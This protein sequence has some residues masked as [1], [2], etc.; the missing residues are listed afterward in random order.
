MRI[1][2]TV[3]VIL[4]AA[5]GAFGVDNPECSTSGSLPKDTIFIGYTR[6]NE[7]QLN[8]LA[9][10]IS[11]HLKPY[12]GHN[13]SAGLLLHETGSA[14][15]SK[16]EI[17]AVKPYMNIRGNDHCEFPAELSLPAS[18]SWRIWVSDTALK[19][20][21]PNPAERDFFRKLM[22]DCVSQGDYPSGQEQCAYAELLAVSDL[23]ANGVPEYWHTAPYI[24]DTG[25]TVSEVQAPASLKR[26]IAACPGCSD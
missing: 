8:S 4:L 7:S 26:V 14:A 5:S 12:D 23:D 24:W 15:P 18:K 9:L 10:F 1:L 13:L 20:R 25:L 22:P 17:T 6:P 2:A 11:K 19:L 3:V 16:T 21:S